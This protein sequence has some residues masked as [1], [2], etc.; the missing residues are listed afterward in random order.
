M[1]FNSVFKGLMEYFA[2]VSVSTFCQSKMN[3]VGF[4][5]NTAGTEGLKM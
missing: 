5:V 4:D 1:G 3:N 2:F